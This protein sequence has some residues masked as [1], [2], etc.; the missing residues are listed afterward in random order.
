M[1]LKKEWFKENLVAVAA[2]GISF[3]LGVIA[4]ILLS[5]RLDKKLKLYYSQHVVVKYVFDIRSAIGYWIFAIVLSAIVFLL[6]KLITD[7]KRIREER[8]EPP[9]ASDGQES[10]EQS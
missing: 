4:G 10:D 1:V 2:S 5:F 7:Q 6:C 3:V 9:T 8:R